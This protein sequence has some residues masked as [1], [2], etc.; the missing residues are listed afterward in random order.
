MSSEERE[1]N[2]RILETGTSFWFTTLPIKEEESILNKQSFWD[3][4]PI[5]YGWRLKRIPS[6]CACGNTFNLQHA[7]RCPKGGLG[8]YVTTIFEIQQRTC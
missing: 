4:Q 6:N 2:D 1:Q 7:L 8:L 3:L 5:R